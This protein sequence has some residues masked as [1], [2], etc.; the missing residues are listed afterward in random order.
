MRNSI[1]F[2]EQGAVLS[3]EVD[4]TTARFQH[5]AQALF[6][7]HP[8]GFQTVV[9]HNSKR[10]K[11]KLEVTILPSLEAEITLLADIR[12]STAVATGAPPRKKKQK[13]VAGQAAAEAPEACLDLECC[14][15]ALVSV[16]LL[17]EQLVTVEDWFR[18]CSVPDNQGISKTEFGDPMFAVETLKVR[19]VPKTV[20]LGDSS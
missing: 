13:R 3:A 1:V 8:R 2:L 18:G 19:K 15:L 10:Q 5:C 7:H 16:L 14:M 6:K 4:A 9:E 20:R 17:H 12:S 11:A